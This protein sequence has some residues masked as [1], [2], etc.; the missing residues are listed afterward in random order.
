MFVVNDDLS[1]YATRGDIVCLNVSAL[2]DSTGGQYE[3]QPGDIV[4][5]K[6]FGK[7]DAENV[8]MQKDF[9]VIA[10]TFVVP[11]FLSEQ[12]TKIGEVISKPKDYWYEIELNPYSNPQT[13][14]G[15]DEDGAKVF[16]LFPE[17]KD[18]TDEPVEPEDIPVVDADLDLTSSRPVE[19]KAI[20]RAVTLLRND[21]DTAQATLLGKISDN[22]NAI[23]AANEAIGVERTRIDNLL[24][25]A[26][27]DGSEVADLRVDANGVTHASAGAMARNY[28][29]RLEPVV[30]FPG[31]HFDYDTESKKL[32]YVVDN[33]ELQIAS[34]FEG[35]STR[36]K[37]FAPDA[38]EFDI[39]ESPGTIKHL[40]VNVNSGTLRTVAYNDFERSPFEYILL[41][42]VQY[43]IYPVG[44]SVLDMYENGIPKYANVRSKGL[45]HSAGEPV[46]V[47]LAKG[48]VTVPV[49]NF[50]K[51]NAY[52]GFV[53]LSAPENEVTV[54]VDTASKVLSFVCYNTTD[55]TAYVVDRKYSFAEDEF[56]LFGV[57]NGK[58]V[59]VELNPACVE[60]VG[61]A[62]ASRRTT[63]DDMLSPM[64]HAEDTFKIVLGGDSITHGVGGTGFAQDGELILETAFRTW[65]RNPNGYCWAKLFKEYIE[66]NYNASVTNN[67]CTGSYSAVWKDNKAALIPED[68]DLFIFTIGTNDR[69]VRTGTETREDALTNFYNNVTEVVE[70]CHNM[71][72]NIVLA[73]PI[74]ASAANEGDGKLCHVYELNGILQKVAA[75][76]NIAYVNLY[77][78][79]YYYMM[80]HG[81]NLNDYLADGLHPNDAGHK[82]LF[83]RY[84]K[85]LNLAP[86]YAEVN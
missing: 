12:D 49:T 68:T 73:S 29:K 26:T 25:G 44:L 61:M 83:Y 72:V 14:V 71:G 77:N 23:R 5:M 57:C 82:L 27:G 13:I 75:E 55:L 78:E 19:N 7:K 51:Y 64:F 45:L 17:G 46:V 30:C 2:D 9:P 59:P 28:Q 16:K 36:N 81:L 67:G 85:L 18:M 43:K 6:I 86:S 53:I 47:N 70:Y 58:V 1:I 62:G 8:L 79:V 35:E 34:V 48:L 80:D 4:R 39:S 37:P 41:T 10:K 74:P 32:R 76:H 33:E 69:D 3:F 22:R 54:S 11:V 84:L 60:Y 66:G 24:S 52:S 20:A 42:Y 65:N 21:L 56:C 63:I 38:T 15:Y 31:G 50:Y 40:V